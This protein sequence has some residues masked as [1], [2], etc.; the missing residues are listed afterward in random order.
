MFTITAVI[1]FEYCS[2]VSSNV[3]YAMTASV[4]G[5]YS[6]KYKIENF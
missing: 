2:N 1:K 6:S 3:V 4:P 5:I